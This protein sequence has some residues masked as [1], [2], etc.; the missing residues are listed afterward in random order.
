MHETIF[1]LTKLHVGGVVGQKILFL[2]ACKKAIQVAVLGKIKEIIIKKELKYIVGCPDVLQLGGHKLLV[3]HG[4][5]MVSWVYPHWHGMYMQHVQGCTVIFKVWSNSLCLTTDWNIDPRRW[6]KRCSTLVG[7]TLKNLG[8][9]VEIS[10]IW[11]SGNNFRSKWKVFFWFANI[12][13]WCVW[14]FLNSFWNE[15]VTLW[16]C[17]SKEEENFDKKRKFLKKIEGVKFFTW[18]WRRCQD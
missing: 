1:S 11:V 7:P 8:W 17:F 12:W 2:L 9:V 4:K 14:A 10:K 5:S 18:M 16:L 3:M 6:S 15:T 13:Y